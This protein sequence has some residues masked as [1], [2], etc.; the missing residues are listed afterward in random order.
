MAIDWIERTE[1]EATHV[2]VELTA[3]DWKKLSKQIVEVMLALV[4]RLKQLKP[5][6]WNRLYFEYWADSGR[7]II[8]PHKRG[9]PRSDRIFSV[10]VSSDFLQSEYNKLPSADSDPDRFESYS[11]ALSGHK[12]ACL[13]VAF[14]NNR[15]KE[16][17]QN[18]AEQTDFTAWEQ[19]AD[20]QESL[21]PI[22]FV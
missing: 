14:S 4:V 21:V 6:S 15:L 5:K 22:Y 12:S 19:E 8:Y 16:A 18:L 20:D 3:N 1:G 11:V 9:K 17:M 2:E 7:I 10:D 13:S